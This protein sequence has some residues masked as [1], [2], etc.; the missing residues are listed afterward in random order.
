MPYSSKSRPMRHSVPHVPRGL[1][2]KAALLARSVSIKEGDSH[3]AAKIHSVVD[4]FILKHSAS[5]VPLTQSS[6]RRIVLNELRRR[7]HRKEYLRRVRFPRL[8]TASWLGTT[9][10]S[11]HEEKQSQQSQNPDLQSEIS[12][13]RVEHELDVAPSSSR[14]VSM[15]LMEQKDTSVPKGS[16]MHLPPP[17]ND[18]STIAT[19]SSLAPYKHAEAEAR[20]LPQERSL[21]VFAG[22]G[23]TQAFVNSSQFSIGPSQLSVQK[24]QIEAIG[25]RRPVSSS[26]NGFTEGSDAS[27][28]T[29]EDEWEDESLDNGQLTQAMSPLQPTSFTPSRRSYVCNS[30]TQNLEGHSHSPTSAE[31]QTATGVGNGAL[32]VKVAGHTPAAETGADA[33]TTDLYHTPTRR[34]QDV[35]LLSPGEGPSRARA[36]DRRVETAAGRRKRLVLG[37]SRKGKGRAVDLPG[38]SAINLDPM[39]VDDELENTIFRLGKNTPP[40]DRARRHKEHRRGTTTQSTG[41][42]EEPSNSEDSEEGMKVDDE[43]E[44][45]TSQ[46]DESDA[47]SL[48]GHDLGAGSDADTEFDEDRRNTINNRRAPSARRSPSQPYDVPEQTGEQSSQILQRISDQLTELSRNQKKVSEAVN[49]LEGK[50]E[51]LEQQSVAARTS[52]IEQNR[53]RP[54]TRKTATRAGQFIIPKPKIRRGDAWNEFLVAN[55]RYHMNPMLGIRHDK[56]IVDLDFSEFPSPQTA[57]RRIEQN[58]FQLP[59]NRLP[60]CWEDLR[61][62]YN[63]KLSQCFLASFLAQYPQ[64][65]GQ[66]QDILD[67]FWQRLDRLKSLRQ[68][69]SRRE[70]ETKAQC[71]SRRGKMFSDEQRRLRK[72]SR[73]EQLYNDRVQVAS[74]NANHHPDLRQRKHWALAMAVFERLGVQGMSS[75]ESEDEGDNVSERQYTIKARVWRSGGILNLMIRTDSA[76]KQTKRSLYGNAPPG[77]PPR[78]R[79]RLK[80]P[81]QSK[82]TAVGQLPINFYDDEWLRKLSAV[83]RG[84]LSPGGRWE[85][86]KLSKPSRRTS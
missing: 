14:H 67:H 24:T 55:I 27:S 82:R 79:R 70:G 43:T 31:H 21:V 4:D 81:A 66:R 57:Q 3:F 7:K 13:L 80:F 38:V 46:E 78:A 71:D 29:G 9:A 40:K 51:I 30:G 65:D 25:W 72:R 36:S 68:R 75:D 17:Q 77:N 34:K 47:R 1:A 20:T 6:V 60:V 52:T 86:P 19:C 32:H 74:E 58:S 2:R 5:G 53:S 35:A 76:T 83:A 62:S 50:V 85:L 26:R 39:E 8:R 33:D 61:C 22:H 45:G 48:A 12:V 37:P 56:D 16:Q 11:H 59:V 28:S 73:Q 54:R 10:S 42:S 15:W 44:E 23:S 41:H 18:V 63:E 84:Q 64:Y 49:K 69:T